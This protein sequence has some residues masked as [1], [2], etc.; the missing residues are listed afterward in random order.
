M[1]LSRRAVLAAESEADRGAGMAVVI[2]VVAWAARR[3]VVSN[4]C[5][6]LAVSEPRVSV[7]IVADENFLGINRAS[8]AVAAHVDRVGGCVISSP[9][10]RAGV[11]VSG[12][13]H[14]GE[15]TDGDGDD[16]FFHGW[17]TFCY[18]SFDPRAGRLFMTLRKKNQARRG[19]R[20]EN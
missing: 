6:N 1:A 9:A 3:G 15:R 14:K 4:R 5:V 12:G 10:I 7:A 20:S 16:S 19:S 13:S 17:V 8:V 2:S 11:G 18:A